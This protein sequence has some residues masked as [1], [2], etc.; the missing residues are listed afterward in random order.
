MT[1]RRW[2]VGDAR[3]VGR[4]PVQAPTGKMREPDASQSP[5]A[6]REDRGAPQRRS[7]APG[8]DA[9]VRKPL[10]SSEPCVFASSPLDALER[11]R[12]ETGDD[13]EPAR[14]GVAVGVRR[15]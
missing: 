7:V 11:A 12:D 5:R 3:A 4:P 15:D 9:P 2:L 14:L 6:I 10:G 13:T 1:G 8:E